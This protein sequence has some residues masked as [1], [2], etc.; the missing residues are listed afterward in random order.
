MFWDT[1]TR[2]RA[3]A[4]ECMRIMTEDEME[5]KPGLKMKEDA[6]GLWMKKAQFVTHR[7]HYGWSVQVSLFNTL[8]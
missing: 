2:D 1:K 5:K 7:A 8:F 3:D 4:K 6:D